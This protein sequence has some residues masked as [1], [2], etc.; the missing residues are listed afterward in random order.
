MEYLIIIISGTTKLSHLSYATP[1]AAFGS[2]IRL[3]FDLRELKE[4]EIQVNPIPVILAYPKI[5]PRYLIAR[6][7][8]YIHDDYGACAVFPSMIPKRFSQAVAADFPRQLYRQCGGFDDAPSLYAA[9]WRGIFAVVGKNIYAPPV[10]FIQTERGDCFFIE[11]DGFVL[12][13]LLF[14]Q[15][16]V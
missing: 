12:S 2:F 13:G 8:V 7:I 9:D 5:P 4:R 16:N 1:G 3:D 15:C 14:R 6:M 10:R 11:C